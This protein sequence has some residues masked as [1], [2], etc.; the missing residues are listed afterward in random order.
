METLAYLHLALANEA[1]ASTDDE[2]FK[3]N[4]ESPKLFE[5]FTQQKL[6][7]S[8]AV[9]L[10]AL[11][12]VLSVVGMARQA[13]ALVKEGDR[14]PE[15]SSLQQRLK[16]LGFFKANVTGY[17]GSMTKNALIQF[18]QAKGLTPDG[19]MG[20]STE[21]SLGEPSKSRSNLV[22]ES[23]NPSSNPYPQAI[24]DS[25]KRILQLGDRGS[26]V[27]ALQERLAVAG[28]P[29]K[30]K[31]IFDQATQ[32]AVRQ[33]QQSQGLTADGIVGPQTIAL[34]PAISGS[35]PTSAPGSANRSSDIQ[36]LQRR[37]QEQGFYRGS[38]DGLWG[39][40]TQSAVEAAQRAYKV[41]STE[42]LKNGGY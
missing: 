24:K 32:D 2:A 18:Q 6:S 30:N 8:T 3:T 9:H 37:L 35:N 7:I 41:S 22:R 34:L 14:G 19:V 38:I 33:F 11:T 25:S 4:G 20:A 27:N 17:F 16:E 31:G 21:A 40:Q 10:L 26:Q 29:S 15:I 1:P 23:S 5:K 12:I 36:A 39:S 28:F 42:Q 13:S